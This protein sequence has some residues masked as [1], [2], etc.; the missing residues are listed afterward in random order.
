MTSLNWIQ[1]SVRNIQPAWTIEIPSDQD[2][3][4]RAEVNSLICDEDEVHL[5]AGCG[6][7]KIYIFNLENRRTVKILSGHSDYIH[8]VCKK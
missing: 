1:G 4:N 7:N 6:D 8:C 2:D 3:F 5:Y